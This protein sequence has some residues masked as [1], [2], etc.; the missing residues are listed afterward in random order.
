[1]KKLP[2]LIGCCLV[3]SSV[4]FA[5]AQERRP[6]E[7]DDLFRVR[8]VGDPRISPDGEWVAYTISAKNEKEDNSDTDVY[9]SPLLGGEAI[10]MTASD[11]SENS[12]RWSSDGRY[13]AFLSGREGKK[14]QVWLLDRRGGEAV[15][16]TDL[17][18]GVSGFVW[19]P[20][21]KKLALVMRDLDPEE[22]E[23]E[24]EAKKDDKKSPKPI[25]VT[26]LQFKRDRAGFLKDFR[27]HIYVFDIDSKEVVQLT[28]GPYDDS[29]P[30]WSPDGQWI[31]F[32]SNRTEEPD[33]NQTTD[34]FLIE[35]KEGAKLQAITT[36]EGSDR[37]PAFSPD[38]KTI[39]YLRGG[40]PSDIWYATNNLATV[41]V[42]AGQAEGNSRVLT[43]GLDR[44]LRAP[45]FAADGSILFLLE[46]R[47]NVHLARVSAAGGA[48]SRVVSGE[49]SISRFDVGNDGT[50][51]VLQGQTDL[52]AEVFHVQGSELNRVSHVNDAW[53]D[54]RW[55]DG[56][57][58][59]GILRIHGGPVG[60]FANNFSFEWQ[61]LAA[62]GYAVI[63]ANPRGSSG[64]GRDFSYEIFAD[65]GNKDF[66]DVTAA[67]DYQVKRGVVD[68]ERLGVG[69]WS[70]GGIL[71]NYVITQ[72][73]RFKAAISGA[74]EVNY[75]ANYGHDHYQYHWEKEL[76]LPWENPD[77]WLRL[78]PFFKVNKVVTPT[79]VMCGQV[80][81]NVPL[82][83]SEQLYQ[84]LRRLG[85]KT[86]LVI[87]PGES[88][89]IRR[90]SFQKDRYRRYVEWYDGFLKE[91]AK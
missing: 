83:N 85:V 19:S 49:R 16:L 6:I 41:G 86:K 77:L 1:M 44:N 51:V 11:K 76:G 59:P 38:G 87:Y 62:Q 48:V 21:S 20:D 23:S 4:L 71:T 56:E 53:L 10:Q 88:H 74:S 46:D 65:W 13:L 24:A 14:S 70:Y 43:E 75:T 42:K 47:C 17:K 36:W 5:Q 54:E 79:L 3:V 60:Q 63:A 45:R 37:S 80:D 7:I 32:V 73:D 18:N 12:P 25:V 9:M 72:T 90:P 61:V 69:G 52:P 84:A 34:I 82:V 57:M 58:L 55:N 28:K 31:S 81:W 30:V 89:G 27:N 64:R 22:E 8:S 2:L 39:A 26:R 67:V 33:S 78:S 29:S 40:V 50:I 68:P 35:A 66:R 15:K 91:P